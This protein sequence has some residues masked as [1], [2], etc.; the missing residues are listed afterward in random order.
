M[1]SGGGTF[2][3]SCADAQRRAEQR[4]RTAQSRSVSGMCDTARHYVSTLQSVRRELASGGCPAHALRGY[5]QAITQAGQ[6]A[7]ASCN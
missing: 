6:T 1:N 2:G 7:R 4:L 5:D 3:G